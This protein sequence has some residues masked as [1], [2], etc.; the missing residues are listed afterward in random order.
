MVANL[1]AIVWVNVEER[2]VVKSAVAALVGVGLINERS[3]VV[4]VVGAILLHT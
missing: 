1:V 3:A 2:V 4:S